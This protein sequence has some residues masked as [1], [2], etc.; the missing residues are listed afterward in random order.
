MKTASLCSTGYPFLKSHITRHCVLLLLLCITGISWSAT[1][2]SPRRRATP[3]PDSADTTA[4]AAVVT[5][6]PVPRVTPASTPE[7]TPRPTPVLTPVPVPVVIPV[8][9]PRPTPIM[10]PILTPRPTA[11]P[12]VTPVSTPRVTPLSTAEV[13]PLATAT[14]RRTPRVTPTVTPAAGTPTPTPGITPIASPT[15]P[16]SGTP[17]PKATITPSVSP[18]PPGGST[19]TPKATITP[20]AS[21]TPPKGTPTPTPTGTP[22]RPPR[23]TP[24]VTPTVSPTPSHYRPGEWRGHRDS[25]DGPLSEYR[26][27]AIT[28]HDNSGDDFT[29]V[30]SSDFGYPVFSDFRAS[31]WSNATCYRAGDPVRVY[32]RTTADAY[33]YV[34]DTDTAG[35]TRQIFPSYYDGDNFVRGGITYSLPGAGYNMTVSAPAGTEHLQIVAVTRQYSALRFY[36]RDYSLGN[37]FPVRRDGCDDFMHRLG[38]EKG[39]RSERNV[40]R[41]STRVVQSTADCFF[42]VY[43]TDWRRQGKGWVKVDTTPN[44]VRVDV[45]GDYLGTTP[46]TLEMSPGDYE[47]RLSKP[48][49]ADE[50]RWVRVRSDALQKMHIE[51]FADTYINVPSSAQVLQS[52]NY[53]V[54]RVPPPLPESEAIPE[55]ILT[56]TPVPTAEPVATS[57]VNENADNASAPGV[58]TGN[59]T[60][61]APVSAVAT[62]APIYPDADA[63]QDGS[64]Q[65][66]N[67]ML[68]FVGLV[69]AA[70]GAGIGIGIWVKASMSKK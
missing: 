58:A 11:A 29:I 21:P 1:E 20:S 57:M 68:L 19:P 42:S 38:V 31:I 41:T 35:V 39:R 27:H 56:P 63:V 7:P 53:W 24:S 14:P 25:H 69:I 49:Y 3:T 67:Q 15:P 51:L 50:V 28:G 47:I 44:N 36:H 66:R 55:P 45:N 70:L 17:T 46:L 61:T 9:T 13:T 16:P 2:S 22:R 23:P 62:P 52:P 65:S 60:Q 64:R 8:V 10:T 43:T 48:G 30:G 37:P 6:T 54:P 32:F 4:S 33:V 59:Q 34:F 12:I 18:T 5:P 40:D 26:A